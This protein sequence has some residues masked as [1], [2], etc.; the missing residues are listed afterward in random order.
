MITVKTYP[1][2]SNK[3]RE[4]SCVAGIRLDKG[5]PEHVRLFPV[6]FRLLGEGSQFPKYSIVEVDVEPHSDKQDSRPESLRPD[7]DTLEIL[8]TVPSHEGWKERYKYVEPLVASSLC[9]IKKDQEER[10]TSLGVFRPAE[11]THFRLEPAAPWSASKAALT[12]QMDLF[13]QDLSP[14]EWVPLDFRYRFRCSEDDCPTHDMGLKDWEAGQSYRKFLRKYGESQVRDALRK[15]W[16]EQVC[17]PNRAVHFFVGN[18]AKHPKTF[19]L[20]GLFYPERQV[21]QYVQDGLFTV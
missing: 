13:D 1:E 5:P 4:T 17:S 16:H 15:R 19:M 8:G 18:M 12:D 3:Y 9:A 21:V 7:L 20:L 6:P 11:V 14:L 10:G 2:L